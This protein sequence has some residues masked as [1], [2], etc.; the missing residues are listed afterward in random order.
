MELHIYKNTIELIN[1]LAEWITD[2]IIKK[3][4]TQDRFTIALSGGET[5]KALYKLLATD[6]YRNKI[7]WS[8]MHV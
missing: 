6:A 7:D 8:K 1:E 5:P 3:L 2:F 4:K